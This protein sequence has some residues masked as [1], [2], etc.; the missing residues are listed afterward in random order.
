MNL[1]EEIKYNYIQSNN[2]VKRLIS[3]FAGA[4]LIS[5]LPYVIFFLF[6]IDATYF[7]TFLKWLTLPASIHSFLYKPWTIVTYMLLH[8]GFFHILF[9]M[10]WLYWLGS[11]FQEY[12]GNKKVY[13]CFLGGGIFGAFVYILSYNLFPVFSNALPH[14]SVIGA[15]AGVLAM[16]VATATLLPDYTIQLI[17]FGNVRLK[18]LALFI[19]LID[20]IMLPQS[21]AGGHLTHLG[22]AFFGFFYIKYIYKY[23]QLIP[24]SFLKFFTRKSKIKIHHR[25]IYM[26]TEHPNKPSQDE[27]DRVLD[28]ISVSG[29]DSLSK[30]E[31]ETL[32][33]ASKD[34]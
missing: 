4:F 27:V 34:D 9:N 1:I 2:A 30:K 26:K 11:I 24:G 10:L 18:Y 21:N 5:K 8:D 32:F 31:K 19:V 3:L 28:K 16:I 15:S 14:A 29:Y 17:I 13:E 7:E 22:G 25:T 23:G 33:K 12:L 6:N 20:L